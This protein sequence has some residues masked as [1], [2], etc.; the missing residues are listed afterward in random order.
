MRRIATRPLM[1]FRPLLALALLLAC[2]TTRADAPADVRA[3]LEPQVAELV[4]MVGDG[5]LQA[6]VDRIAPMADADRKTFDETHDRLVEFTGTSGKYSGFDV[7]GYKHVTPRF[8]VAYVLVYFQKRP[9][10]LHLGF[11][12]VDNQWRPQYLRVETDFHDLLESL[13]LQR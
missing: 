6:L 9:L 3:Q 12:Q 8:V 7:V 11:Y 10:L 5:R 2:A 1:P 13:P 4:G